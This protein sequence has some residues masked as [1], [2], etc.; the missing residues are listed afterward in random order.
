MNNFYTNYNLI[1]F[2]L[3]IKI[4]FNK[5]IV[6]NY[7]QFIYFHAECRINLTKIN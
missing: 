5:R 6:E 7:L 2:K 1:Q 4:N 3:T